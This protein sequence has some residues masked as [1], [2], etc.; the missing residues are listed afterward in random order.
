MTWRK[1]DEDSSF[2][3]PY[4]K[5]QGLLGYEIEEK[6][7]TVIVAVKRGTAFC[8]RPIYH[9]TYFFKGKKTPEGVLVTH[10]AFHDE[11]A[12]MGPSTLGFGIFFPEIIEGAYRHLPLDE[13]WEVL[14]AIIEEV[15]ERAKNV[16]SD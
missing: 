7:K 15:K 16:S 8:G 2:F 11:P 14:W 4:Q 1:L 5:L 3:L 9:Y 13:Q 6:P 12:P 10:W